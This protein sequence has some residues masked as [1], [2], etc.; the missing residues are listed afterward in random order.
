MWHALERSTCRDL[1]GKPKAER[2][3]GIPRHKWKDNI[4]VVLNL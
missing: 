2:T 3:L 4:Q 1:V